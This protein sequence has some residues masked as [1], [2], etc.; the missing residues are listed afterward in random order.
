MSEGTISAW[1]VKEGDEFKE[2][3]VILRIETDKAEVDVEAQ[4]AGR[5]GKLLVS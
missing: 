5:V 2:G 1:L 4:E 3:D